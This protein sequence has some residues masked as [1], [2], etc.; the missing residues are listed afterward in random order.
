MKQTHNQISY[1]YLYVLRPDITDLPPVMSQLEV[2]SKKKR[3]KLICY[4]L[5]ESSKQWLNQRGIDYEYFGKE[6]I[7][8][9][10]KIK[11]IIRYLKYKNWLKFFLKQS[12]YDKLWVGSLESL[13]AIGKSVLKKEFILNVYEIPETT[14][15]KG[16]LSNKYGK[17]AKTIIVPEY[18]RSHIIRYMWKLKKTP[19]VIENKPLYLPN[20]DHVIKNTLLD[21]YISD[22]YK[23]ILYQ[24]IFNPERD[25]KPL[26][27]SLQI[28]NEKYL[29]LLMT[30]FN[31]K[32]I[33]K[34]KDIYQHTLHIGFIPAP[35]H[36]SVTKI[37]HIGIAT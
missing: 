22:G 20:N 15:I 17:K 6:N 13:I 30:P 31:K 33:D 29:F 3:V 14:G 36:L 19:I 35:N 34:I 12:N 28:I 27:K 7:H 11:K 18:N 37:A 32:E 21:K 24:G 25:L 23:I 8:T 2:L 1:D 9:S 16:Y 26:A 10:N 4:F 5:S